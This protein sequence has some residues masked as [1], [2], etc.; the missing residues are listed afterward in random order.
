MDALRATE[1]QALCKCKVQMADALL[2]SQKVQLLKWSTVSHDAYAPYRKHDK[3]RKICSYQTN[4][5]EERGECD[6]LCH[7]ILDKCTT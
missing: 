4:N 3:L 7:M 2:Q 5:D 1:W 6:I